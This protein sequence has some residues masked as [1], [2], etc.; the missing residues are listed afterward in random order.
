MIYD[1]NDISQTLQ[2]STIWVQRLHKDHHLEV[3][4]MTEGNIYML[5]YTEVPMVS[6]WY[7]KNAP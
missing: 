4:L 7:I 1:L 2:E 5:R 3:S 6:V